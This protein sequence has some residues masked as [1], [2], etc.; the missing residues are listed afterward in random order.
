MRDGKLTRRQAIAVASSAIAAP[1]LVAAVRAAPVPMR[2]SD[3]PD[4]VRA[5]F[6]NRNP[7]PT[8]V[9]YVPVERVDF[10][11]YSHEYRPRRAPG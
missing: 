4:R 1:V 9:P 11:M 3:T 10:M 8:R 7:T 5:W 2:Y 6:A